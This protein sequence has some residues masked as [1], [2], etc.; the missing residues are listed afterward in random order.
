MPSLGGIKP[1]APDSWL[2]CS[3]L[4]HLLKGGVQ[5]NG[6]LQM[7]KYLKHALL[8]Q[9]RYPSKKDC[10][11]LDC[12]QTLIKLCPLLMLSSK[13]DL[14]IVLDKDEY[15]QTIENDPLMAPLLLHF[16]DLIDFLPN[17]GKDCLQIIDLITTS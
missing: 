15:E 14:N 8:S 4:S 1:N 11:S 12:L 13:L 6:E 16:L 17:I 2:M 9:I 7:P 10:V 5:I 3:F